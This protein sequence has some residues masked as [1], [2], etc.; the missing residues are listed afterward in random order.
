MINA[1]KKVFVAMSGGVD[2]SV[3]ACLL[4]K[5]GYD[6]TGITMDLWTDNEC[7]RACCGLEAAEDARRVCWQ[8]DIPH[9]VLNYREIF[10]E[11]VVRPF[12]EEYLAGR[13]PNP[14]I[15]CNRRIKFDLLLDQCLRMGADYL[16][17]GHYARIG[18]N[19]DGQYV[20]RKGR[21][22]RKD[23]S[24]F[25]YSLSQAEMSRVLFPLGAY[26]KDDVRRVARDEGL[27]VAQKAESQEICFV[28]NGQY[29]EFVDKMYPDQGRQGLIRFRDG[30]ILGR[31]QGIHHFT[32]GQRRG[33]GITHGE[34]LY[35]TRLD[36]DNSTVWVGERGDLWSLG[37]LAEPGRLQRPIENLADLDLTVKI[38]YGATETAAQVQPSDNH[39]L[40]IDFASPQRAVTPGQT[41]VIYHREDVIAGGT[42]LAPLAA[43][44]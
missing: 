25:L 23:Q 43:E 13:T 31:H 44:E 11:R 29:T 16:A 19:D 24:Y 36:E 42:I 1:R 33:L 9:Y 2:S 10:K 40:R 30:T 26:Y 15:E 7:Q 32:L 41:V 18:L 17:T 3:A 27:A 8:L 38:R 22:P 20:L 14:C 37:L 6:V 5:Y 28:N 4:K 34:P 39:Y 21:D 12:C 35:V